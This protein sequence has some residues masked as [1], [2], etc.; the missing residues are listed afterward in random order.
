MSITVVGL[1]AGGLFAV[2]LCLCAVTVAIAVWKRHRDRHRQQCRQRVRTELFEQQQ[3]E[4]PDWEAWIG[5]LSTTEREVLGTVVERYL[6]LVTGSQ[7]E[8][9]LDVADLLK[10][11]P[12]ADAE[13]DTSAVVPRLRALATLSLLS[14][15]VAIS[16]L[17]ATC[18]DSQRV[19]EAA[20]RLLYERRD[21]YLNAGER[22]TDLLLWTGTDPLSIYG[23]DTLALLNSGSDTPLLA[24]AATA[25]DTWDQ[26]VLVQVCRVLERTQ[27]VDPEATFDWLVPLLS[28]P[29][30]T[31]RAAAVR[32]LTPHGWR[33]NLRERVDIDTLTADTDPRVRRAVYELLAEWG[34]EA[35]KEALISGICKENDSRCQLVAVRCLGTLDIEPPLANPGWPEQA[36]NWLQAEQAGKREAVSK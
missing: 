36:W 26:A 18:T 32:A 25:A 6:R 5:S 14:Y 1:A 30:P 19:R 7:Q 8:T 16:R 31:V 21:E 20:A 9:L 33:D 10:L 17:E 13:L 24:L 29:D 4:D 27:T 34:D 35:A 11:G 22:G 15:P 12:R 28:A 3:R 23:L 2:Y